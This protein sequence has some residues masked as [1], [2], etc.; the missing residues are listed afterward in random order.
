MIKKYK[1]QALSGVPTL[2][3]T[4]FEKL[5][6]SSIKLDFL[7]YVVAGGDALKLSQRTKINKILP[8]KQK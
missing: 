1:P 7:K 3:E 2:F 6:N 5:A 4:S 8:N